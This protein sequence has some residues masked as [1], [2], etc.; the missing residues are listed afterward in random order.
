MP[1]LAGKLRI[2]YFSALALCLIATVLCCVAL[3]TSYDSAKGYFD[4][5]FVVSLLKATVGVAVVL[6][7]TSLFLLP[8]GELNGM[9]PATLPVLF[10]SAYMAI[11]SLSLSAVLFISVGGVDL[12]VFTNFLRSF[13]SSVPAIILFVLSG[14]LF[15]VATAYF[16]LNF[17]VSGESK[18]LDELHAL[19]GYAVLFASFCLIALSYFDR[20]V[21]MN[22][23]GKLL[24]NLTM[25][26]YMLFMLC[27][28]RT[29]LECAKPRLYFFSGMLTMLFSAISSLP[30][31]IALAAGK[32]EGPLYP[33]YLIYNLFT[34]GI[35]AYTAVRLWVFVSARALAERMAENAPPESD[36]EEMV[37]NEG[38]ASDIDE[39][40]EGRN[41]P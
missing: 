33:T 41:E 3:F 15:L 34:L 28:L 21:S 5:S 8:K 20:T 4:A 35:F 9:S 31:L 37:D 11:A 2:Y 16:V 25:I 26:I 40:D 10:P 38:N 7:L 30:W 32:L 29:L 14:L 13:E 18:K 23:P 12:G 6:C 22:A 39:N 1:K 36:P 19:A 27:E 24:F 17:F